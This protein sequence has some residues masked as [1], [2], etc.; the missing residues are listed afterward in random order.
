LVAWG[1][2]GVLI[3]SHCHIFMPEFDADRPE[4]LDRA[5]AAGI[6]GMVVIGF[7]LPSSRQAVALAEREAD[8]YACVAIHPHHAADLTG[9]AL[10][11]LERL[12]SHPRVVGIGEIGLDYYRDRSP[13]DVQDMAFRTQ[14]RLARTRRLPVSVHDRDAHADTLRILDEEARGLPAV[15]L[16]CFSGDAD[17][18]AEAW[19]RGYYT[20]VGGPVTY[21]NAGGLRNWLAAAPQDRVLLETDAPYLP[22]TPHRGTRNEPAHLGLVASRVALLWDLEPHRVATLTTRNTCRALGLPPPGRAP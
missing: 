17:M 18:A 10:F 11:D 14:L 22:P 12:A 16:H 15:V 4:V 20:A 13:R 7:D 8:V 5:R 1:V 21:S 6:V 2:A 3:D 19:A 9:R